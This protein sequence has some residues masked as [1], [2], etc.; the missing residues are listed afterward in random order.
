MVASN[1]LAAAW[2]GAAFLRGL[3]S[4]WFWYLLRVAQ[5]FVVV[6]TVLGLLLLARGSEP[7]DGLH[8]LY[9]IAPL[10]VMVVT[11]AMRF[12]AAQR[13]LEGVDDVEALERRE[14]VLLARRV[15]M[16]EMAVMSI[17]AL[18]IVTLGLRAAAVNGGFV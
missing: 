8:F 15:V 4:V 11:E 13:E 12:G 7:P 1:A 9:G 2:G 5:G 6:Q 18:L 14:Q 16:R 10:V 3:P 17:G